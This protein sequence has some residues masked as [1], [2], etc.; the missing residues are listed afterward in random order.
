MQTDTSPKLVALSDSPYANAFA[1]NRKLPALF[2]GKSEKRLSLPDP[3][4]SSQV[5]T[6]I[7]SCYPAL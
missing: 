3:R 7:M 2:Q 4:K 5:L 1:R 6:S